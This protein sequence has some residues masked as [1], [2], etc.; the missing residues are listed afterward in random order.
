MKKIINKYYTFIKYLFSAGICLL[1]DLTLFTIFNYLLKDRL[2]ML[3]I[4][5]S[6]ILARIISSSI[7]YFLN[8]NKVFKADDNKFD[9]TTFIEYVLLVIT[10]MTVSAVSVTLIYKQIHFN[11]TIIKFVVEVILFMVNFIVQRFFIF[12]KE[13][14]NKNKYILMFYSLLSTIA[15]VINPILTNDLLKIDLQGKI[16][17]LAFVNT[18]L[19]AI[20][21][22]HYN[23]TSHYKPFNV[24]S[25]IFTLLLIFGYSFDVSDSSILVYGNI[26]YILLS[27]IKFFGYFIFIDFILNYVYDWI[28]KLEL[29]EYSSKRFNKLLNNLKTHPFKTSFIILLIVYSIYYI[30]FYPGIFGYDPSYQIQEYMGIKTF[31]TPDSILGNSSLITQFNPVIH[32]LLIGFLFSIGHNLNYDNL[33]LAIY[34][35][36]QMISF[37][38]ILS[39]TIKVMFEEKVNNKLIYICLIA[40][41]F[42]PFFPFYSLSAFKDTYYA[43]FF[44]LFIVHVYKAIKYKMTKKDIFLLIIISMLV[45]TFRH[46]GF[47]TVLITLLLMIMILKQ[48]RKQ[49]LLVVAFISLIHFTYNKVINYYEVPPTSVREVLSVPLQQTSALIVNNEDIIEEEDKIIIDNIIDYS[50]VKEKYDP[51]L[52]D[53]I[54]NTYKEN[55][56]KK[57]LINYF[58]VWF[59]YLTKEPKIYIEATINNIYG[60]LYPEKQQWYFYYKKYKVLNQSGFD[61]HYIEILNPLRTVLTSYGMAFQYI[62]VISLITS[63]GLTAWIYLYLMVIILRNKKNKYILLLIPAFLTIAMCLVGPVNSYYRY[64]IPYSMSLPFI[65]SVLYNEIKK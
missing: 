58:S 42:V 22:R 19:Y 14:K 21:K 56:T 9:S 50:I 8:R 7:N 36:I 38:S 62:P 64:V 18:S 65:L 44:I 37:I 60:Y 26:Q 23:N 30:A 11:E 34:T 39:Y 49:L 61:Y 25:I 20:Y 31:Y 12:N 57:D 52:S 17:I 54:K 15:I 1:L 3:S 63:I 45:C 24:L 2:D 10:Q 46:N 5:F 6:T 53:P 16:I 55:A 48:N 4:T 29:K 33:G 51:E 41:L 32:T 35:L 43:M 47:V 13:Y 27:I 40:Y 59:K 28:N